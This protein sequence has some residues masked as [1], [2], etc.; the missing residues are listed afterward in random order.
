MEQPWR[1]RAVAARLLAVAL[2]GAALWT[3]SPLDARTL[4]PAARAT[5]ANA[6]AGARPWLNPTLSPDQRADLVVAQLTLDEALQLVEG[7]TGKPHV[8][9]PQPAGAIGS[10][11]YVPG[12]PRLGVPA[13]QETDGGLGVAEPINPLTG[14]AIRG[15]AGYATQMPA[16][17][18]TAA[19]WN[20]LIAYNGG[21]VI[22]NEAHRQG[23]NVLLGGGVNLAREPRNGRTFEYAGED[24]LL[25]GIVVGN[26][27]AGEQSQHVIATIK[28]YAL[29]DQETGRSTL[30][31]DIALS[32][33]QASDLLAFQIGIQVG[34]PGSVMCAYNRV[35]SVYSCS[36]AVLQNSL[37]KGNWAYPGWVMSDWGAAHAT[38][39]AL[40]GLD[41]ESGTLPGYSGNR[42]GASLRAAVLAGQVPIARIHDMDHRILRSMFA[43]GVVD[44]PPVMKPLDAV[45][46]ANVAQADEEQG[47]VLLENAHAQL[48]LSK[49][50]RSLA[51]IG[52]NADVGVLSGSG[53][54]QVWPIGGPAAPFYSSLFARE[55]MWDPSS[56]LT[57]IAAEAPAAR[58]QFTDGSSIAAAVQAAKSASVAIVFA[59]QPLS[60][61]T[62]A[63]NLSLPANQDQLIAAVAAANPHTVVVLE[64]GGP[65]KMPWL[66]AVSGVLE[67]WYPGQR[68]GQA[69]ARLLFGDVD[70]SGHLPITFPQSESQLPRPVID[71]VT[72]PTALFDVNYNIEGA[73]VGYKWFEAQQLT[74]LFPFGFGLSYTT[75]SHGSITVGKDGSGHTTYS[76]ND[77]NTGSR[78]GMDVA[79]LYLRVPSGDGTAPQRL[80]GWQKV[81]LGAGQTL[82]VT[83]SV[84]PRATA[85]YSAAGTASSIPAVVYPA[86]LGSS[87][88]ED[89]AN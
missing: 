62:D 21:A 89:G 86:F 53:S 31:S 87:S 2:P 34:D 57:S 40:N 48:P 8:G 51:V 18:A 77:T 28:H 72:D 27:I 70:P 68:G 64:T 37:L 63:V 1:L 56:P 75:F 6:T 59:Y 49:A 45:D 3:G 79:Q 20:P 42:F 78:A 47:A 43:K 58:V 29:N 9:Y 36:N 76:F 80:V 65:V 67:A 66:G 15:T 60:E 84:D 22:G 7:Y 88:A 85:I 32:A 33:A 73:N 35:N 39:D 5:A 82:R 24:P 17:I 4:V 50:V 19:T 74:P 25:A 30:S 44:Y 38:S 71:G 23:F 46:D 13:L 10:A 54:V 26:A 12:I 55:L 81:A 16:G 41:Q 14:K 11:G 83:I 69:I 61:G 52:F